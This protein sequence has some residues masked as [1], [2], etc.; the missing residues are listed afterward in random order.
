MWGEGGWLNFIGKLRAKTAGYYII[1]LFN[2]GYD[3]RAFLWL[4]TPLLIPS[5]FP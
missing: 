5:L 1:H 4:Q 3:V 2:E